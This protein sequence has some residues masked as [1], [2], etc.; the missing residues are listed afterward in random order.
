MV[1]E[2]VERARDPGLVV[3]AAGQRAENFDDD[4]SQ[5]VARVDGVWIFWPCPPPV[6]T[7]KSGTTRTLAAWLEPPLTLERS[8]RSTP[9]QIVHFV[10][11][12]VAAPGT[13]VL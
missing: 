5:M 10:A 11:H 7:V 6:M 1:C 9:P 3:V 12:F 2:G 13:S 4:P 8:A